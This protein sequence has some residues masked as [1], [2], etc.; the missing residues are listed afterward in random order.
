MKSNYDDVLAK[1]TQ[2]LQDETKTETVVG[3][4]FKL[5]EFACVPVIRLGV[6]F[7][8]GGGEAEITPKMG[9]HSEGSGAGAGMGIE[10]MGF[11]V[12]RGSEVS[13]IPTKT[14]KG[15]SAAFEKL[16]E[17]L[18]QFWENRQHAEAGS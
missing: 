7:G 5:G 1:I 16:P 9:G 12:S 13:F 8:F 17:M 2:F 3:K 18:G 4:E 11:L 15:L 14:S 10:P 6:G